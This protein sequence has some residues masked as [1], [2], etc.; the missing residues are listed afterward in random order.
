MLAA[1]GHTRNRPKGG[2]ARFDEGREACHGGFRDS[3][4]L[5]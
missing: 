5:K 1:R 3:G 2:N 4:G